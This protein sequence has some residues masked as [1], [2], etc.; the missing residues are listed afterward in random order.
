[1]RRLLAVFSFLLPCLSWAEEPVNACATLAQRF[2]EAADRLSL[3]ELGDLKRC[4]AEAQH[5]RV[6][7]LSRAATTPPLSVA[8]TAQ[9]LPAESPAIP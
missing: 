6:L 1:M 9:Q 2:A 7:E 5:A 4:V 3:I 8:T